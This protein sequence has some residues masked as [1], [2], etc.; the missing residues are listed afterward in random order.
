MLIK[1]CDVAM[2]LHGISCEVID[3]RTLLPWDVDTVVNSVNKTG[4]LIIT[5]EA[6]V[7]LPPYYLLLLLFYILMCYPLW[8]FN[9][10]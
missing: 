6:P 8:K 5:H 1:A 7:S 9:I 2:K 10:F 4:R 3:L